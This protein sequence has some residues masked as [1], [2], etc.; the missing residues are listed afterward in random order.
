M[1]SHSMRSL[2]ELLKSKNA[3]EPNANESSVNAARE[4][5]TKL[6]GT[7]S[8][9]VTALA[10]RTLAVGE[11]AICM[12]CRG[13]GKSTRGRCARCN[14]KGCVCPKCGGMR[15]VRL[16]RAGDDPWVSDLARCVVC[17][18]GNNVNEMAEIKA[19]QAYIALADRAHS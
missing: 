9:T 3:N 4:R 14:G 18:E 13:S 15:F 17:C 16:R 7:C 8:N 5:L 1:T 12:D 10:H 11:D 19:V 2:G 6:N